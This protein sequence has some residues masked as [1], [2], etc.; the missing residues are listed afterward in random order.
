MADA[1]D[2]IKARG[3][4]RCATLADS[5][6]MG[7]QDPVTRQLVGLDVDVCKAIAQELGVKVEFQTVAISARI[8]SLVSGRADVVAAALG[9]TRDRAEQINFSSAYYQVPIKVLVKGDSGVTRFADLADKRISVVKGSTPE[10]YARQQLPNAKVVSFEDAPTAFLALQQG[11]VQGM[12]MTTP[13]AIRFHVRDQN[14]RFLEETLHYEPNCIGIKKGEV[15]LTAAV[16]KALADMESR[17]ELQ[18]IWD[19]WYGNDTEYKLVREKKLT[20]VADFQ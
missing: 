5:V 2:D 6:P 8:P 16:D 9:Y 11:K 3:T 17:G 20:P 13:A 19:H 12:G 1:L 14:M 4:L 7:Y 10:I 15:A 18:A